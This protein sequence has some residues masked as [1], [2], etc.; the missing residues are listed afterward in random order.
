MR[1]VGLNA[2]WRTSPMTHAEVIDRLADMRRFINPIFDAPWVKTYI[3]RMDWLHAADQGISADFIGNTLYYFEENLVPGSNKAERYN[4]LFAQIDAVYHDLHVEDRL[5][6]LKPTF[7][8]SRQGMKLRCRAAQCR[9]L[10]PVVC[11]LCEELCDLNDPVEE[12]I[13]KAAHHLKEVYA[14][15]SGDHPDPEAQMKDHSI[16]FALQ[17]VALHD[18]FNEDDDRLFIIKPKMHFF[19]LLC[20]EGG[21]PS[22][23]WCYRDEDFG[24]SISKAARRR[25]G[26]SRPMTTSMKVLECLAIGTPRVSIR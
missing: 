4:T 25:G 1:E 5:D 17:Y 22:R 10:V 15:L 6:C 12:A 14:C 16:G 11:R 19:L 18:H 7:I 23:N 13:A 26:M 24:G 21:R 20:S 3:F 9:A 2:G 8:E